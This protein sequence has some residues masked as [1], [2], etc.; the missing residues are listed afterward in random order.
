MQAFSFTDVL[1]RT[2]VAFD[3]HDLSAAIFGKPM[4]R[5]EPL[6]WEYG[7]NAKFFAYPKGADRSPNWAARDGSWKLL[8]NSDGSGA[9]LYDLALSD[10]ETTNVAAE[11][12]EITARLVKQTLDWRKSF[13]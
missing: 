8:V 5:S 10:R 1:E 4:P 6:F 13:P 11:H 12:P 7:R 3:G 2:E 9:E